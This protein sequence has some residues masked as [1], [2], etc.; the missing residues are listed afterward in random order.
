MWCV[1][2]SFTKLVYPFLLSSAT[3]SGFLEICD[4][5]NRTEAETESPFW[6]EVAIRDEE[7]DNV[8]PYVKRYVKRPENQ[9]RFSVREAWM[10]SL[11]TMRTSRMK[12]DDPAFRFR[13]IDLHVFFNGVGFLVFE[14]EPVYN[15]TLLTIDWVQNV[16]ADLASLTRGRPIERVC[17]TLDLQGD[18]L[19]DPYVGSIYVPR[20]F[21]MRTLVS[22]LLEPLIGACRDVKID[23][24]VDTFLLAYGAV[25]LTLEADVPDPDA[26]FQNFAAQHLTVLRKTLSAQNSS[27]FAQQIFG[28]PEHNY[29]PYHNVIHT[30]SLEGGFVIAYDNGASHF[31]GRPSAAMASFR[32][33]YFL[34]ML[35]A[36]HQRM[37]ILRYATGAA[38]AALLSERAQKLRALR[39]QIYDF[40][41]RC[42]FSQASISEERD[43]LYRRWQRA[44]NISQM[45]DE[46]IEEIHDIDD[47]LAGVERERELATKEQVLRQDAQRTKLVTYVSFIL[48]PVSIMVNLIQAIPVIQIWW[49][50][51]FQSF[52]MGALFAL[53]FV[54]LIFIVILLISRFARNHQE[55]R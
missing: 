5:I 20:T 40:T 30:Q 2:E 36:L 51:G 44:F 55:R 15:D 45:Y 43:Q 42:Y 29:M 7:L 54:L 48:L 25:Q 22:R 6:R 19:N 53:S 16:N 14:I 32:R 24:M 50:H 17:E 21:T 38:D 46:L 26:A 23:P 28:D 33:H 52:R 9:R 1:R 35:L 12:E 41:S 31:Q 4:A 10:T 47:Y 11:Q 3:E 49:M 8:I 34:M 27:H 37:S 39:E 18:S 13:A